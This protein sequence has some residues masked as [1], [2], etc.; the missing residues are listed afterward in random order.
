MRNRTS[1]WQR[2]PI[3]TLP[4]GTLPFALLGAGIVFL[5]IC[6]LSVLRTHDITDCA[7]SKSGATH[8]TAVTMPQFG[9]TSEEYRLKTVM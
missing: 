3:A 2:Q 4:L 1:E 7:G 6:G 5:C 8:T 9:Y